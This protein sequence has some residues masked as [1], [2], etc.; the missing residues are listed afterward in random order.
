MLPANEEILDFTVGDKDFWIVNGVH[1]LCYLHPAQAGIRSNMNLV[2]ASGHVYSFLLTEISN[3]TE[4]D[5]DLKVFVVPKEESS[6][7]GMS[8]HTEYARASELR[9]TSRR[10]RLPTSRLPKRSSR[11]KLAPRKRSPSTASNIRPSS[12]SITR[13]NPKQPSTFLITAIYH[14]DKFTYIKCDAQ[15]KPTIYEVKDGKPNLVNFDLQNGVYVIPKILDRG[16]LAI[17]KQ[18]VSFERKRLTT[19]EKR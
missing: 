8:G 15:E 19:A 4:A 5:P 17:G 10:P 12:S 11:P 9:P 18:K 13:T 2:T 1:N 6:I 7:A 14:D 16:Y 3:Q